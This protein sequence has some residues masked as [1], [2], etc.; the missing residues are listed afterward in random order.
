MQ[1]RKTY[2]GSMK[3]LPLSRMPRRLIMVISTT[4]ATPIRR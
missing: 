2:V 4:T 3:T 1:T